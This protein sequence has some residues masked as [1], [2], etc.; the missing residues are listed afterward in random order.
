M[1][2]KRQQKIS[3]LLQK[4]LGEIFQREAGS[5]FGGAMITV[6]KVHVTKDLGIARVFLS[7]F[8]T[9]D[10]QALLEKIRKEG[11]QIRWQ[12]GNKVKHQLRKIPE[13]HFYEDDS[14][15]YIE[16]IETLLNE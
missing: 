14:L 10:K 7:L 12:L 2:S 1:E 9:K 15:D 5:L 6:T 4:D 16:N 3:K 8:A 11:N 13:L